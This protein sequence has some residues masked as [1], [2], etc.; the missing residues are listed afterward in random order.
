MVDT[1]SRLPPVIDLRFTHRGEEVVATLDCAC[2]TV[3]NPNDLLPIESAS[4]S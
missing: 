4:I 2:R 3:A 1:F